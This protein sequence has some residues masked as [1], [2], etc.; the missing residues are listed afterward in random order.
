MLDFGCGIG[1]FLRYRPGTVGVDINPYNVELCRKRGVEAVTIHAGKPL[2]FPDHHFDAAVVDNVLEHILAEDVD[3]V[4]RELRRVCKPHGRL[5][6]GVPGRKGFDAD[7]DHKH[8]YTLPSLEALMNRHACRLMKAFGM[9]LNWPWL[10]SR[11]SQ[12]C[13]YAVFLIDG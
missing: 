5:L 9:P 2:P 7:P 4:L 6:I 11:F 1:D 10:E 8:F 3:H 12:Y 13:L